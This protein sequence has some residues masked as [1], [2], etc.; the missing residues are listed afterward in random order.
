MAQAALSEADFAAFQA[1]VYSAAGIHLAPNKREMLATRLARRLQAL[2][3]TNYRAYYDLLMSEDARGEEREHFI[4]SV[5]TNKTHFFREPHHFDF[6]RDRVI[7]ELRRRVAAGAPKRLRI[8][9]CACSSG[10]EPYS[11]A[12]VAHRELARDDYAIEIVA[13]DIDTE[14][15]ARAEAGVYSQAQVAEVPPELRNRYFAEVERGWQVRDELRA[16]VQ[17][18]H[19]NLIHDAFPFAGTFD[20]IFI[21]NVIIYFDRPSQIQ[22]FQRLRSFLAATSYLF[23][24]HSESLLHITDAFVPTGQ[25][26]YQLRGAPSHAPRRRGRATI[27]RLPPSSLLVSREPVRIDA[28]VGPNVS[29]CMFDAEAKLGGM[30]QITGDGSREAERAVDQLITQ[31]VELGANRSA[32]HAKLVGGGSASPDGRVRGERYIAVAEAALRR[33]GVVLTSK[34]VGG[35]RSIEIQ[36]FTSS[37]R[38]LCRDHDSVPRRA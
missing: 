32:L 37:G 11:L 31:L 29:I 14:I 6:V 17:L 33:A 36:F 24:G 13:S 25:T 5:T 8:W 18:H 26:V 10:E 27:T 35:E 23:L 28:I 4:N 7:P 30:A 22:L 3:L 34:R 15:L 12:M 16:L 1:L 21:R 20:A 9:S 38:L 2:D 19:V